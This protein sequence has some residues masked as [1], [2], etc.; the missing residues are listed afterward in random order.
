MISE[1]NIS[2]ESCC[3]EAIILRVPDIRDGQTKSGE[4]IDL[5]EMLVE[6]ESGEIWVKGWRNQAQMIGSCSQGEVVFITDVGARA[7]LEGRIELSLGPLQL[8]KKPS[9]SKKRHH[10]LSFSLVNLPV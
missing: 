10:I 4:S 8:P 7:G 5:A 9:R 6:D 1:I 2:H 3:I